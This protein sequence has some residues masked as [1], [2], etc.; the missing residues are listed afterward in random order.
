MADLTWYSREGADSRFLTKTEGAD[1][2]TKAESSQGDAALGER[3]DTVQTTAEAALPAAT[4]AATYATKESLAGY[5]RS[6]DAESTYATKAA[7]A[8]AQIG[9]GAQ[10]PD[11]SGLATKAEVSSAGAALGARIDQVKAT[12]EAALTPSAASATYATKASLSDYLTTAA[13]AATYFTGAQA[14]T[15]GDTI[16]DARTVA[17]AALPRAD[18][19]TTYATKTEV[20][21][22]RSA[23][24]AAPDLSP[25]L[26]TADAETRYASKEDLAKAQAGGEVD[27]SAYETKADAQAARTQIN[28]EIERRI[29]ET[30][31]AIPDVGNLITRDEVSSTYSTKQQLQEYS[32]SALAAFAGKSELAA[33]AKQETVDQALAQKASQESLA[34]LTE[35]VT[36]VL[37]DNK[38][39]KTG[40]RYYSPVTYYWP[41]YYNA[42][43]GTSKWAKTLTMGN[44]LGLVILNRN[45]GNWDA[46]DQ[47]FKTQGDMALSAGAK[48][49]LFYVKTQYGVAS[50]PQDDQA[51]NGVPDPDKYTKEYILGQIKNCRDQY[52]DLCQGVFLDETINGWGAQAGRVAWYKDLIDTIRST[53]G[54]G[55]MIVC[56][57]GSNIS[58]DM[59][60]LDFDVNMMF[61]QSAE[62]FITEDPDAPILPS[63]MASEP[64]T[65]WWAVVHGVTQ[66]NYRKVFEKAESLSIGHLY[67]TDGVLV[68]DPNHGG[69]WEPVGNPYQ[70]PPSSQLIELTKAWLNGTLSTRLDVE[71][72]KTQLAALKALVEKGGGGTAQNP[73]LVL[74]PNDPVPSGTADDTVIIRRES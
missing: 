28:A 31:A 46:F 52:K 48:R 15:M 65:R 39:F 35:N 40:Q 62:K 26:R 30:K 55:F 19:Q 37:A 27:L 38:P 1:L 4:A 11:L 49:V 5:L 17:D 20:E 2:A 68:E 59:V 25:Y 18:A 16:R 32:Q 23:I 63:H 21:A 71:D 50:L 51:R 3:I 74:G 10:A 14:A 6:E 73:F 7:L 41:D 8:Q 34:A 13:A 56:N 22:V 70:N 61:E 67:I 72:L 60:K 53:Y 43:K 42:G 33:Y 12:A 29:T 9:G 24:P 45:S 47:D 64:S 69:Q 54:S 36:R 58:T 66:D 57:S 44:S